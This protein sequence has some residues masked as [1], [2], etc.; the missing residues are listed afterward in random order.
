MYRFRI[1]V[2][3]QGRTCYPTVV[4]IAWVRRYIR[5]A[6]PVLSRG[7]LLST[8][9]N[10][11]YLTPDPDTPTAGMSQ[12][13]RP[14]SIPS[15]HN[16]AC[17]ESPYS[18]SSSPSA[19]SPTPG[20]AQNGP[21]FLNIPGMQTQQ[22]IKDADGVDKLANAAVSQGKSRP[23][24]GG[25]TFGLKFQRRKHALRRRFSPLRCLWEPPSCIVKILV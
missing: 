24:E 4:Q 22:N 16:S 3:P 18:Q 21:Y 25:N 8:H 17:D 5:Q 7:P 13:L 23:A 19:A 14:L 1:I 20:S 9:R 12:Y 2:H 15:R 11:P 10:Y 6:P